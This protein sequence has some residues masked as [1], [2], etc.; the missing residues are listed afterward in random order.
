[1]AQLRRSQSRLDC[2]L[3]T[4][5]RR[6]QKKHQNLA[7]DQPRQTKMKATSRKKLLNFHLE[8]RI[9]RINP[10]RQTINLLNQ[11]KMKGVTNQVIIFFLSIC[12]PFSN[13]FYSFCK[14][15]DEKPKFSF[16]AT[17]S[18]TPASQSSQEPS[19]ETPKFGFG[20]A[21]NNQT[22][23]T[24]SASSSKPTFAF[25]G[26]S[27]SATA[28]TN[29]TQD[30]KPSFGFGATNGGTTA[31]NNNSAATN[32]PSFGLA[33]M[34]AQP[35]KTPQMPAIANHRLA[36]DRR[37]THRRRRHQQQMQQAPLHLHSVETRTPAQALLQPQ[38]TLRLDLV[39]RATMVRSLVTTSQRQ[40]Q[41]PPL[42]LAL[43]K[44]IQQVHLLAL[45]KQ[46]QQVHL[47]HSE[48]HPLL[49]PPPA[50]LALH[51]I[52]RLE[53]TRQQ[54][55]RQRPHLVKQS[56][57]LHLAQAQTNRHHLDPRQRRLA[58]PQ[59][60]RHLLVAM[61]TNRLLLAHPKHLNLLR[62]VEMQVNQ[63]HLD[64]MQINQH[65][66]ALI[67]INQQRL[68]LIQINQHRLDQ[69]RTRK[70]HLEVIQ[71]NHQ[72]HLEVIQINLQLRL[73]VIQINLQL[74]L[75]PKPTTIQ[76][77]LVNNQHRLAAVRRAKINQRRLVEVTLHLAAL[78]APQPRV[79][80]VQAQLRLAGAKKRRRLAAHHRH[81][82]RLVA[83]RVLR[84]LAQ[85][86]QRKAPRHSRLAVAAGQIL[87]KN[88]RI[89]I[90]RVI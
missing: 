79:S 22:D 65:R 73:E 32:K 71:I 87:S 24:K 33:Q 45:K 1:M 89:C 54:R 75:V 76:H 25:G 39:H 63:H 38:T 15:L 44:Q 86:S 67:Q 81:R 83:I 26:G 17:K 36:L 51:R 23:Q 64:L 31:A 27:K 59:I 10:T 49:R 5:Q 41:T 2:Q 66:L 72:L 62:L 29:T 43:N 3:A 56:Q 37:Q 82:H 52:K 74:R 48:K 42:R 20:G 84:V 19:K 47:L 85:V 78:R 69:P 9:H 34:R 18:A 7:L 61:Q 11:I 35:I 55:R 16:G 70:R 28:A 12:F 80:L 60:K 40:I 58:P 4:Q 8:H 90:W 21:S 77:R 68:D 46:I 50:L 14:K 88:Q 30:S 6:R 57:Q 53:A 13:F